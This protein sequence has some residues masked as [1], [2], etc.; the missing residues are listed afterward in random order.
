[1]SDN[2]NAIECDS[3]GLQIGADIAY[4]KD[5]NVFVAKKKVFLFGSEVD[6][7]GHGN[8]EEEAKK[9]LEDTIRAT[10]KSMWI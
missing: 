5:E 2:I 7:F 10:E 1:M 6:M 4:S 9:D 3:V 8:T